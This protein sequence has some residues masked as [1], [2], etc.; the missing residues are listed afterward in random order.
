MREAEVMARDHWTR[1]ELLAYQEKR[2]Q[3]LIT[4]AVTR[5]PYYNEVL[6]EDAPERPFIELPTLP[7]TTLPVTADVRRR[8]RDAW[9]M[10]PM[11]GYAATEAPMIATSSPSIRSWRLPRTLW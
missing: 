6:G 3:A 4:H 9:G 8:L 10:E 5:S 2:V 1:D 11:S 7:K